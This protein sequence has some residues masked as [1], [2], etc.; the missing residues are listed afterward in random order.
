MEKKNFKEVSIE[1]LIN[2]SKQKETPVVTI[3]ENITDKDFQYVDQIS[4]RLFIEPIIVKNTNMIAFIGS[5]R[6]VR[7]IAKNLHRKCQTMYYDFLKRPSG[8]IAIYALTG[9]TKGWGILRDNGYQVQA[10]NECGKECDAWI[11]TDVKKLEPVYLNSLGLSKINCTVQFGRKKKSSDSEIL[12]HSQK[13]FVNDGIYNETR[14]CYYPKDLSNNKNI[15]ER[16]KLEK[17]FKKW[18]FKR[19]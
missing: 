11:E 8:S 5:S 13:N 10:F 15:S 17:L 16:N 12:W 19:L 4:E 6:V 7:K 1:E 9:Y 2:Y 3:I 14:N 18:G